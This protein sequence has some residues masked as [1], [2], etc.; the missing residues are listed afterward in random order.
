L[1]QI[2]CNIFLINKNY[3]GVWNYCRYI[4]RHCRILLTGSVACCWT[5]DGVSWVG[6]VWVY[7]PRYE[8]SSGVTVSQ[9]SRSCFK[10]KSKIHI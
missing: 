3:H 4:N 6:P 10:H 8:P 1:T 9:P 7:E 5:T 2:H